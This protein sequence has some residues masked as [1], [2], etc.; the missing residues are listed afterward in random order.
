MPSEQDAQDG[1][2]FSAPRTCGIIRS[3]VTEVATCS[4]DGV[5]AAFQGSD[6]GECR[7]L[8]A[9]NPLPIIAQIAVRVDISVERD[10]FDPQFLA[11]LRD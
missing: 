5:D 6:A 10:R 1:N 3:G 11:E 9:E 2:R 4:V 7:I 8:R